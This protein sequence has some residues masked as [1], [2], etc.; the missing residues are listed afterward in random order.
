MNNN[1]KGETYSRNKTFISV[2][3]ILSIAS[4]TPERGRNMCFQFLLDSGSS[5]KTCSGTDQTGHT[6]SF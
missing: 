2:L 4:T 3:N 5:R 1:E 6:N